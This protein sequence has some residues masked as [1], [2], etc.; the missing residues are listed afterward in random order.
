MGD[1][2]VRLK[3][4][5]EGVIAG[6]LVLSSVVV[7]TGFSITAA[8]R[9]LTNLEAVLFQAFS[10]VAGLVGSFLFGRQ[11]A[12]GAA[13]Q[14]LK[15]HARSAFRRV[16]SLYQS[17]SRLAHAIEAARTVPSRVSGGTTGPDQRLEVL[18]AIVVEQLSTADDAL[19]DWNDLVPEDVAEIRERA[20]T[21]SSLIVETS[22]E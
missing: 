12:Q 16:L 8:S 6:A 22:N 2:L 1:F 18:R 19:E 21:G 10:L 13:R 15:P 20:K 3:I 14:M 17:I 5:A 9:S 7:A 11:S 4:S